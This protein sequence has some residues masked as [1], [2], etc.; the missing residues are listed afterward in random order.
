MYQIKSLET[1]NKSSHIFLDRS[2]PVDKTSLVSKL[3]LRMMVV[4]GTNADN[5]ILWKQ[6][7]QWMHYTIINVQYAM[8][9]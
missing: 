2:N 1:T 9:V 6:F 3:V 8:R 5:S 4:Y 7:D